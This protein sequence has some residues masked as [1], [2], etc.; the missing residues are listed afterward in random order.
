MTYSFLAWNPLSASVVL[1]I[2][3][4]IPSAKE[5][6]EA[7]DPR[8][9]CR[10]LPSPHWQSSAPAPALSLGSGTSMRSCLPSPLPLSAL[11]FS[12]GQ[13]H[14]ECAHSRVSP[15]WYPC[16]P[17]TCGHHPCSFSRISHPPSVHSRSSTRVI[18]VTGR[19]SRQDFSWEITSWRNLSLFQ[20]WSSSTGM[21]RRT[22]RKDFL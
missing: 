5:N 13:I 17:F 15:R 2:K 1:E 8:Q 20:D 7:S 18:L 22:A 19:C 4:Q 21:G 11:G 16:F 6:M 14:G 12:P 10:A 3:P 9:R